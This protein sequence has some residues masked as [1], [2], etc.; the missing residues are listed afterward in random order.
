MLV[1]NTHAVEK[2]Q[3][4]YNRSEH[5]RASEETPV[6]IPALMNHNEN[7]LPFLNIHK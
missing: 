5:E 3:V 1:W 4:N 2:I 7:P 6:F